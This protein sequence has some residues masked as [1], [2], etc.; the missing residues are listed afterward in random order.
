MKKML[1]VSL[2]VSV[3]LYFT[4]CGIPKQMARDCGGDFEMGCR[5]IFGEA[6]RE[7]EFAQAISDLENKLLALENIV[8][9]NSTLISVLESNH[10]S[11]EL[12]VQSLSTNLT[13]NSVAI[14]ILQSQMGLLQ[15][16][17]NNLQSQSNH[18]QSLVTSLAMQDSVIDYL[19]CGGNGPG[20]DEVILRTRLGKLIAYFQSGNNRFLTNL[21]PGSYMTTDGQS[22]SF[23]VNNSG[24]FC[25]SLGCR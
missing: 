1:Y 23:T 17:V 20:Y 16:Q 22:C 8:K 9:T 21:S 5:T 2:L 4:A 10:L 18:T 19:D 15:T 25:D 14:S 6:D 7:D 11:L 12:Q 3:G 24:Q 13:S